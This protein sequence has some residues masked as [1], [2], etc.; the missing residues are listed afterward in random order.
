MKDKSNK[1][2]NKALAIITRQRNT[3]T[4]NVEYNRENTDCLGCFKHE[5]LKVR[6]EETL[7]TDYK[8]KFVVR[9][10]CPRCEKKWDVIIFKEKGWK[11]KFTQYNKKFKK[12]KQG[13]E[14]FV[15]ILE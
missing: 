13:R 3:L 8:N 2:I 4:H 12:L 9:L 6:G 7:M 5:K 10:Q 15:Q 11:T 14:N 1:I